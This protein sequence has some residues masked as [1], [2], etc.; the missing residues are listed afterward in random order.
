LVHIAPECLNKYPIVFTHLSLPLS[1]AFPHLSLSL[2]ALSVSGGSGGGL[3]PPHHHGGGHHYQQQQH[4]QQHNYGGG[5][6]DSVST[7][8][9]ETATAVNQARINEF[10]FPVQRKRTSRDSPPDM[11]T[12]NW[13][14]IYIFYSIPD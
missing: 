1:L 9:N 5:E 14:K 12:L 6:T 2:S 7:S 13:G 4:Q 10:V 11:E 3:Y 8:N